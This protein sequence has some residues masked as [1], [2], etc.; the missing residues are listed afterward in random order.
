MTKSERA[1]LARI[2]ELVD[3]GLVRFTEHALEEMLDE[4]ATTDEVLDSIRGADACELQVN[5]RYRVEC[6]GLELVVIAEVF[7]DALIVTVFGRT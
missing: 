3:A 4:L 7:G 1:A 2:R 5:G 6:D